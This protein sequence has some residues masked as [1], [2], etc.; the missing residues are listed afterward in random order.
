MAVFIRL[1]KRVDGGRLRLVLAYRVGGVLAALLA[2]SGAARAQSEVRTRYFGA[3]ISAE[4]GGGVDL[5]VV[6]GG[7]DVFTGIRLSRWVSLEGFFAYH[8]A[9][10][11]LGGLGTGWMCGGTFTDQWHWQVFGSRLWFHLLHLKWIDLSIAPTIDFGVAVDRSQSLAAQDFASGCYFPPATSVGWAFDAGLDFGVELRPF[12]WLG[13]RLMGETSVD[14][15]NTGPGVF[16]VVSI[17][18]WVGPVLRF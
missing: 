7:G 17:S 13:F 1:P 5:S 8:F 6:S 4:A 10:P 3:T 12:P 18:G 2:T 11:S 16:G 9:S 15:G 14:G